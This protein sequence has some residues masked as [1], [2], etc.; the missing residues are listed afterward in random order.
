MRH[1]R[2]VSIGFFFLILFLL[3]GVNIK[4]DGS[5]G[6]I[7]QVEGLGESKIKECSFSLQ[8]EFSSELIEDCSHFLDIS[9]LAPQSNKLIST[10]EDG[11]QAYVLRKA[12][13]LFFFLCLFNDKVPM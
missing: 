4:S 11:I 10:S 7:Y 9:K 8:K 2:Q 1:K 6:L 12:G 13:E 5:S 3:K